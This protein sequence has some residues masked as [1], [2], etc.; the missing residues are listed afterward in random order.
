MIALWDLE[1]RA[2]RERV[3]EW[4]VCCRAAGSVELRDSRGRVVRRVRYEVVTASSRAG[5]A[6]L[7]LEVACPAER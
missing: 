3:T 7:E 5:M 4:A 6:S 2:R 1:E